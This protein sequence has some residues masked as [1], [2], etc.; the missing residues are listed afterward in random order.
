MKT[1]LEISKDVAVVVVEGERGGE[2][3]WS[4]AHGQLAAHLRGIDGK[5]HPFSGMSKGDR[6]AAR[7]AA[8]E[9]EKKSG[10]A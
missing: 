1:N 2:S 3:R 7:D 8:S 10:G 6:S 9:H 4:M 5:K